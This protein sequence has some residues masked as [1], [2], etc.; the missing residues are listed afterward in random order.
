[1][2]TILDCAQSGVV[3]GAQS[4]IDSLLARLQTD[5]SRVFR[6]A[7]GLGLL[8]LERGARFMLLSIA[9]KDARLAVWKWMWYR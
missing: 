1:M 5:V 4:L 8:S 3:I 7:T 2:T 9:R 6:L